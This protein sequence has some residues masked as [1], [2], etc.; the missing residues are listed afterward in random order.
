M[1]N[2]QPEILKKDGQNMFAVIPYDMY[3]SLLEYMNDLEDL[4]DLRRAKQRT[5]NEP[6]IPLS[7]I[8]AKAPKKSLSLKKG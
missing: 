3:E 6:L 7:K 4:L 8:A 2:V 5:K 1:I